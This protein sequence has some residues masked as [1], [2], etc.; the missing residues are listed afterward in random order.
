MKYET[1]AMDKKMD[2]KMKLKEGSKKD[3][4]VDAL[5]ML[6]AGMAGKKTAPKSK[7]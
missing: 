6:K 5:N 2:K 1:S 3:N 7:K 4:K